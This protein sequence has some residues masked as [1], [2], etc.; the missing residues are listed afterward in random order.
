MN[1]ENCFPDY[2][3]FCEMLIQ[4]PWKRQSMYLPTDI[5]KEDILYMQEMA[6]D[7]FDKITVVLK[8]MPRNLLL[9]LRLVFFSCNQHACLFTFLLIDFSIKE[10]RKKDKTCFC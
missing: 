7:H 10:K 2:A 8:D 3:I 4:R 5:T 6:R 1:L 9:V